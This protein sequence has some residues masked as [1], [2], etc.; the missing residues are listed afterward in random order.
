V[1]TLQAAQVHILITHLDIMCKVDVNRP[2][3]KQAL[4]YLHH[5]PNLH[6]FRQTCLGKAAQES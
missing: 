6:M 3:H 1:D 2:Q 4:H 5:P